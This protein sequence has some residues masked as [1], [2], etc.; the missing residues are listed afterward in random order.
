M[1]TDWIEVSNSALYKIGAIGNTGDL[2]TTASAAAGSNKQSRLCSQF[3]SKFRDELLIKYSWNFAKKAT[4]LNRVD[5]YDTSDDYS[6]IVTITNI[7][8]ANPAVV[9]GTNSYSAGQ[10]VL[11]LDVSG[12]T[13]VNDLVFEIAACNTA[14]FSLLGVDA[15]KWGPYSSGGEAVRVE[16]MAI[17]RGG[18]AYTI[19]TDCICTRQ[20]DSEYD[21]EILE[22]RLL[23]VDD[24]PILIYTKAVTD[25]T[26]FSKLFEECLV[27]KMAAELCMPMLGAKQG[28][29]MRQTMEAIYRQ[30][31]AEAKLT[32]VTS[33]KKT[34]ESKGTWIAGRA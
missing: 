9:T 13:E 12:M 1:A 20:L 6:D 3:Y 10:I 31:L 4:P 15:G 29:A 16:P 22:N 24:A 26:V 11:I 19:P 32:E 21:F 18:Y 17:Y 27:A 7:S 34:Y 2:V 8:T 30:A 33:I 5:L 14:T 28:I 23:T 25:T